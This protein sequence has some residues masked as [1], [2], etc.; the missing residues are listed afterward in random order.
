MQDLACSLSKG[1]QSTLLMR[2]ATRATSSNPAACQYFNPRS[3][4]EERHGHSHNF[5]RAL[6]HFNPRSSCEERRRMIMQDQEQEK[7]F[8]PRSSC[9]E[10]PLASQFTLAPGI[11][12]HAPHARSDL[13][14]LDWTTHARYFNPRSSCEERPLMDFEKGK[15]VEF[16][17]TLLMRGATPA[18][19]RS[20]FAKRFQ[21]TL[22]MRG[23]TAISHPSCGASRY[24]NP[25]S[26]CE[27]RQHPAC[28]E[29]G[30][31]DF[32]PRSS[33]EERRYEVRRTAQYCGFQSTLLMRG[34]T[35]VFG[36]SDFTATNF[37]PR[38]SCEE[39][40]HGLMV[41]WVLPQISIH[42]PHARSD[43]ISAV[44]LIMVYLFQ[45]TLLMR[46]AT[47]HFS[48]IGVHTVDIFQSTLLMRGATHG[49]KPLPA[50]LLFQ[51]T[52]LMRGA[53]LDCPCFCF[54]SIK[55]ISI[56]APHARSD[57][58]AN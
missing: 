57:F 47:C 17:S 38:S 33:C 41:L 35:G 15:V 13:V 29:S 50:A 27:E 8:N 25:R 39:R 3:S 28:T 54:L 6:L 31:S 14:T 12:I 19:M 16:Q 1:F 10:R 22:L 55:D 7:N 48:L 36:I 45:S 24:F 43:V 46:G 20:T 21:S 30:R 40:P 56:H 5:H 44:A 9:E 53:T 49:E 51:S 32:N 37:N 4:C 11:S 23:A 52:L 18:T 26:S 34:A 58:A 42:A 2:G